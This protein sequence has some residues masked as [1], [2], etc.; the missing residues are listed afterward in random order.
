MQ[1]AR[2]RDRARF[3]LLN[4]SLPRSHADLEPQRVSLLLPPAKLRPRETPGLEL[5]IKDRKQG[6]WGQRGNPKPIPGV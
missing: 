2:G 6:S 3:S 1:G 5:A 4:T